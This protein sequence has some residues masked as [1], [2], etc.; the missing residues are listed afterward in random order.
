MAMVMPRSFSSGALSIWSNAVYLASL[1]VANTLVMAAVSVVLPWSMCPIVPTFTCGLL[2]T[3]FCFAMRF[4]APPQSPGAVLCSRRRPLSLR[5][6][7]QPRWLL[8]D[9]CRTNTAALNTRHT[10][11]PTTRSPPG[12]KDRAA[13]GPSEPETGIE[14]VTPTLPRLCSTPELLG[15]AVHHCRYSRG[16]G[17]IADGGRSC[18][19]EI[20]MTSAVVLWHCWRDQSGTISGGQWR[21]RTSEGV[22]QLI[23]SQSRLATSVTA[24]AG[25]IIASNRRACQGLRQGLIAIRGHQTRKPYHICTRPANPAYCCG[26][27]PMS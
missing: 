17:R 27:P 22:S 6:S 9:R 11:R 12:G 24:H 15:R 2:R 8:E 21:I 3:N 13:A 23:Y 7:G 20:G 25:R 26:F 10:K 16:H 14:P 4:G 5:S 18:D 1:A 19:N